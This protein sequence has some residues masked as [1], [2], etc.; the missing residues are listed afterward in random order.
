MPIRI[1]VVQHPNRLFPRLT[2]PFAFDSGLGHSSSAL[3][4]FL[5]EKWSLQVKMQQ[6]GVSNHPHYKVVC[7]L[8]HRWMVTVF[9][10]KYGAFSCQPNVANRDRESCLRGLE[11]RPGIVEETLYERKGIV[12]ACTMGPRLD[13]K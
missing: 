7:F 1:E 4:W 3:A 12:F 10:E 9:T 8:D 6:L 11:E 13:R 2:V 5:I